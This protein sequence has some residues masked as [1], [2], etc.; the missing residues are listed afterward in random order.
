MQWFNRKILL[1]F[2]SSSIIWQITYVGCELA[3]LRFV[4]PDM[5]GIW[6][7][8]LLFQSYSAISRLGIMNAMNREFPFYL[9]QKNEAKA[10]AVHTTSFF[11]VLMNGIILSLFFIGL[12]FYFG[13]K[14][15]SLIH[16]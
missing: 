13:S 5:I 15:L 9:G 8:V 10:E 11:F 14:G 16:I 3:I 7:L 6:Q 12:S 4:D 2:A 1:I